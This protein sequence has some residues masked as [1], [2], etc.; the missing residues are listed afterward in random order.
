[1]KKLLLSLM[2]LV[3]SMSMNAQIK[4]TATRTGDISVNWVQLWED[5]P[6]FAE[7]NVGAEN[8]EDYGGYYCWGSSIDRDSKDAYKSGSDA[9]SGADD[10]ATNLWGDNWRMPTKEELKA[11]L[12]N[13]D[14][15][16]TDNYN[17]SGIKGKVFTGKGD[18]ASNSVFLPANGSGMGGG[19][20]GKG[21]QGNYWPSTPDGTTRV[22]YLVFNSAVQKIESNS[23]RMSGL[24]VRAVLAD[25]AAAIGG[26]VDN[27]INTRRV[28]KKVI[29]G[30]K[31]IIIGNNG[32]MY[33]T[34]GIEIKK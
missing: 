11:L 8:A 31:L 27:A 24:A 7:Y 33:N 21:I 3:C 19:V 4:G 1:M 30:S 22:F 26:V 13:C 6:R 17:G 10:T 20:F 25:N 23:S 9:L 5:G 34:V 32:K 2:A 18:Y 14:V 28:G 12:D 29:D 15:A 16:W